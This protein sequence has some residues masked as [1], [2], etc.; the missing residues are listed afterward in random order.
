MFYF[1]GPVCNGSR[2]LGAKESATTLTR[3]RPSLVEENYDSGTHHG[4][5][6]ML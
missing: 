2:G 1:E 3:L 4:A 6:A 5:W